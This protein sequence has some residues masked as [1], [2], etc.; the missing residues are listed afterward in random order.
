MGE[1]GVMLVV[2]AGCV[3]DSVG[4]PGGGS[5]LLPGLEDAL[6]ITASSPITPSQVNGEEYLFEL[7]SLQMVQS[8]AF[9]DLDFVYESARGC[10]IDVEV[11]NYASGA[12][13]RLASSQPG[14]PDAPRRHF[15]LFSERGLVARQY[16]DN[17]SRVGCRGYTAMNPSVAP[18]LRVLYLNPD[19]APL[20]FGA[21]DVKA[22]GGFTFDGQ[23][24]WLSGPS[25]YQLTPE[26]RLVREIRPPATRPYATSF[27]AVAIG[28]GRIWASGSAGSASSDTL[29]A[30][31]AD[32]TQACHFPVRNYSVSAL[33]FA[34]SSLWV[35][36][37]DRVTG[38]YHILEVDPEASCSAGEAQVVK[39]IP[40]PTATP[41]AIAS[42]GA[43]IVVAGPGAEIYKIAASGTVLGSYRPDLAWVSG[44]AWRD[45]VLWA[46]H[47]G[48]RG[49][50]A[51]SYFISRFR[52]L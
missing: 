15:R 41:L 7:G 49:V 25:L 42:D 32:G 45:G 9:N 27:K 40:S 30:Y 16:L 28:P 26:G 36:G 34:G 50:H 38:R 31:A 44:L 8:G 6:L 3:E 37:F 12:W 5:H 2:A 23:S 29:Y 43:E 33:A 48:P 1:A 46:V 52:L 51:E 18:Q 11:L 19:Y 47:S 20:P 13:D 10:D 39:E 24:I 21:L 17:L 22:Y 35:V 14:C 4:P